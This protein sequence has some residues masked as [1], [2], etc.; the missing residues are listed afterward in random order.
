MQIDCIIINK[1]LEIFQKKAKKMRNFAILISFFAISLLSNSLYAQYS[2]NADE[3]VRRLNAALGGNSTDVRSNLPTVKV[4][5]G[6]T[7]PGWV[8]DPYSIYNRSQYI[9]AVSS[10]P[11]RSQAE[12]KALSALVAIFGQSIRS[13]FAMANLYTEAVFR[14]VVSVSENSVISDRIITAASMDNLIGAE[15]GNIWD[16]GRGTVYAAAFMDKVKTISIYSDMIIINNR[17]IDL[18]TG[19]SDV[20]KNSLDGYARYKV[21]ASIAGINTN[22]AA[23]V[24]QAGGSVSSLNL[25]SADYYNLEAVNI[26]RNITVVVNVMNDRANRIQD[27]FAGVLS[28]EGLRTRG[29]NSA[30]TLNVILNLSEVTFPGNNLK[31]CRIEASVNLIENATRA[32]LFPFS[33]SERAGHSTYINAEEAA[34]RIVERII[35]E[36][37][38][39]VLREYL[40]SLILNN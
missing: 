30:Y 2:Y 28:A 32:S 17:N 4:T 39:G 35:A 5:S 23:V 29:N 3:A 37:Y 20:Q 1:F 38:P 13:D 7:Q 26:I 6:G 25:K 9:A 40:A 18:L 27:A 19:M 10:A 33:F 31:F 12:A 36:K 16:S 24:S 11:N 14:G 21:A 34:F 8:D 22:Y 15:I